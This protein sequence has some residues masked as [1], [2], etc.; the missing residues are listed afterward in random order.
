MKSDKE[1]YQ[2]IAAPT[3]RDFVPVPW[4][5][6]AA[7]RGM[8]GL[9][10]PTLDRGGNAIQHKARIKK[11]QEV[12]YTCSAVKDCFSYAML[13]NEPYGV[14]GGA[15]FDDNKRDTHHKRESNEARLRRLYDEHS[16]AV[17]KSENYHNV[18]RETWRDK[19][20]ST[21]GER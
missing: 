11:A 21:K 10:H 20:P 8:G 14:W 18:S 7:C 17:R 12:C 6:D 15:W 2:N 5:G 9:F 1:I 3:V 13:N 19:V 4:V 16:V